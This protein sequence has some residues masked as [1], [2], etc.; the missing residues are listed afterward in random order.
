MPADRPIRWT[1]RLLLVCGLS[2]CLGSAGC[3]YGV[4]GRATRLP[5][6]LRVIAVPALENNTRRYRVEQRFTQAIIREFL[7]RG[8]YRIVSTE[9][10]ADAVL[11]GRI[12]NLE[13]IP[14][15]FDTTINPNTNVVTGRMATLPMVKLHF[16]KESGVLV[17]ILYRQPSGFCCHV[18][19]IDYGDW[20]VQNGVRVP[21]RWT[22]VGP[23]DSFLAYRFDSMQT[24]AAVDDSRFAKPARQ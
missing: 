7:A 16:D 23:R 6:G 22:V 9:E 20:T 12:T 8:S 24:N 10:S 2:L 3:C 17:S 15:V 4:G 1:R 19:R 5:P 13:S 11:R 18:F 14:V 21:M